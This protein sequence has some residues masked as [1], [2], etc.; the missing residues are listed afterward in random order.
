MKYQIKLVLIILMLSV[1]LAV[2]GNALSSSNNQG[3][4]V[5]AILAPVGDI[6]QGTVVTPSATVQ[7]F[8][9]KTETFNLTFWIRHECIDLS[10]CWYKSTKKVVN[11]EPGTSMTVNF[12]EW[13]AERTGDYQT[14]VSSQERGNRN[15]SN[16][17]MDGS[18]QV[19]DQGCDVGVTAILAPVGEIVEGSTLTPF[20]TAHN[21]CDHQETFPVVFSIVLNEVRDQIEVY[22]DTQEVTLPAGDSLDVNFTD[23]TADEPGAYT[24]I[25]Y[26]QSVDDTNP[27]NDTMHGEFVVIEEVND[28][29]VTAILAPVGSIVEGSTVTPSATVENFGNE[30]ETF[31]VV[32]SIV[33]NEEGAKFSAKSDLTRKGSSLDQTEVYSDTQEVTVPAGDSL[34][35]NFT[36]WT[37]DEPGAYTTIAYTQSVDDTNPANDTMHGEF[38]VIEEVHD[39]GVNAILAPVGSIVEGSTVT[40]SATVENFGNEAETFNVTF[41]FEGYTSTKEVADLEPGATTTVLFDDWTADEPGA[42]TTTAYTQL[43]EDANPA[44]DT[45]YGEF[46]VI[47]EVNDVG[48]TAILAPVGEIVEGTIVTPSVTVENFG[49]E[50]ETFPVVFSI[51]P[52]EEGAKF[53]AKSDL[54]RKGSSLDQTEV[55]SDTQEV[56]VPAGNSLTV[57]FTDWTADEPGAY[58]TTAYTQLDDDANPANDTMYGEFDVEEEDHDVGVTEIIE[59]VGTLS[60]GDTVTP[61]IVVENFGGFDED[62]FVFFSIGCEYSDFR[63]IHLD[64][65]ETAT[66]TFNQWVTVEGHSNENA[67]T[68]LENDEEPEND[69]QNAWITVTP[70]SQN[71]MG[72]DTPL[73]YALFKPSPNPTTN[74]LSISF[75]LPNPS[76]VQIMVYDVNGRMVKTL[77][78]EAK[79]A[80]TYRINACCR[81]L[82]CGTYI[83]KMKAG[84]FEAIEKFVVTK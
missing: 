18:F 76:N 56:T 75:A 84:T 71:A 79:A 20:A 66:I 14:T 5:T 42:Y 19:I 23:W 46:V 10:N 68:R 63:I 6:A 60:A 2:A 64:E 15:R 82:Q 28:V 52:N 57:N 73:N 35:V 54:T 11:L 21:F 59:P 53:S 7:N 37:A 9:T 72:Y 45:M 24:T 41:E 44:N 67:T 58:T 50:E 25:A 32:F 34:D 77:L 27:A 51:V 47:E 83:A 30:E 22:S 29:G 36:D 38:E 61:T 43:E 26:T 80:G 33:L 78:S 17:R 65:G 81:S 62:F 69:G 4:S 39:A 13:T 8:G 16:I 3:V 12:D 31:P 70:M 40:P 74:N 55:Y 49:N 1:S 48:V